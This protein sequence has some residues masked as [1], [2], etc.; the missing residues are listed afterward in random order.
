M[1]SPKRT[2]E[3]EMAEEL[4]AE[5]RRHP[6]SALDLGGLQLQRV[7]D[8]LRSLR[9]L[10][11]LDLRMNKLIELPAWLGELSELKLL[12]L[13]ENPALGIPDS[14]LSSRSPKEILRYYFESRA[15]GRPL[16]ELKLLLVGRGGA[17][18]TSLVKHLAGERPNPKESETHSI[19]IREGRARPV[20]P[21][22]DLEDPS[23]PVPRRSR[24]LERVPRRPAVQRT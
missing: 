10:K 4:I 24:P 16:Q 12:A 8:S 3:A 15:D 17:G 5:W 9:Q 11:S 20:A 23:A 19:S 7:P 22:P 6:R 21:A 13:G 2:P 1:A 14:I 18:K